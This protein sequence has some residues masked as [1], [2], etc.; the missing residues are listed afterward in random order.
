MNE[1]EF[2]QKI[3]SWIERT[4]QENMQDDTSG[5]WER[6]M[7]DR[8][9]V[10]TTD[11]EELCKER[12]ANDDHV[13]M[14]SHAKNASDFAAIRARV[15]EVERQARMQPEWWRLELSGQ[16]KDAAFPDCGIPVLPMQVIALDIGNE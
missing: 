3:L 1:R 15:N 6:R 10:L 14:L 9:L 4:G 7:V 8:Y 11:I 12:L 16:V 13:D 5:M 2:V